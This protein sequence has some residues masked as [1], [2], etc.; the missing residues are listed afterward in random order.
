[1]MSTAW[2]D[3]ITLVIVMFGWWG[4]YVLVSKRKFWVITSVVAGMLFAAC[5]W[6]IFVVHRWITGLAFGAGAYVLMQ[7]AVGQYDAEY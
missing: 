1:M 2:V 4:M 7:I 6:S 3:L 5:L